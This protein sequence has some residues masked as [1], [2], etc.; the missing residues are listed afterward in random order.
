MSGLSGGSSSDFG[1]HMREQ[2]FGAGGEME[3]LSADKR[4]DVALL[5]VP[6]SDC[7]RSVTDWCLASQLLLYFESTFHAASET[8]AK[9]K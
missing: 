9:Q 7:G 3:S 2:T 6:V 1:T 8:Q 5:T 4:A